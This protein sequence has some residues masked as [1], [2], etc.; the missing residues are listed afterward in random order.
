VGGD[1]GGSGI[2]IIGGDVLEE[3]SLSLSLSLSLS[4]SLSLSLSVLHPLNFSA[5]FLCM[6]ACKFVELK[7]LDVVIAGIIRG[8][9]VKK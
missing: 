9:I 2:S 7:M 8:E 6:H 4:V 1:A 5:T 3:S